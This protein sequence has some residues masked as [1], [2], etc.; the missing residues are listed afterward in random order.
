MQNCTQLNHKNGIVC[1]L[2]SFEA[3]F[4]R[5]LINFIFKLSESTLHFQDEHKCFYHVFLWRFSTSIDFLVGKDLSDMWC[6]FVICLIYS[7]SLVCFSQLMLTDGWFVFWFQVVETNLVAFD[8]H[9]IIINEVNLT[10]L[11]CQFWVLLS[12]V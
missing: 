11:Y 10:K 1:I 7:F 4:S 3:F 5:L 12:Y 6:I 9:W 8:C 2:F